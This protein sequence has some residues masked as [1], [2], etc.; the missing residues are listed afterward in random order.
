MDYSGE[1]AGTGA[2]D[3]AG[4]S[5]AKTFTFDLNGQKYFFQ[6]SRYCRD[7]IDKLL[8]EERLRELRLLDAMYG[9]ELKELSGDGGINVYQHLRDIVAEFVIIDEY[10]FQDEAAFQ[11]FLNDLRD[12][13]KANPL[14]FQSFLKTHEKA[15]KKAGSLYPM[16][17]I[18]LN[19]LYT[20]LNRLLFLGDL[21][22]TDPALFSWENFRSRFEYLANP[23]GLRLFV[24]Q[25]RKCLEDALRNPA[26]RKEAEHILEMDRELIAVD[27]RYYWNVS[28][29]KIAVAD[30]MKSPGL[31]DCF[32]AVHKDALLKLLK[33]PRAASVAAELLTAAGCEIPKVPE[34]S[35]PEENDPPCEE[36]PLPE[37]KPIS[38]DKLPDVPKTP[39]LVPGNIVV[40]GR[41]PEDE[42]ELPAPVEWQVLKVDEDAAMTG[43][44]EGSPAPA[45]LL[46]SRF[47]LECRPFHGESQSVSWENSD[48]RSW[49]NGEFLEKTFSKEEQTLL[50][51]SP[52]TVSCLSAEEAEE[53]FKT[54]AARISQA[55]PYAAKNGAATSSPKTRNCFIWLRSPGLDPATAA[56]IDTAG[57]ICLL[58]ED[59]SSGEFAVRP[60]I[61]ISL[62][63]SNLKSLV[64]RNPADSEKQND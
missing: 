14:Y 61:R 39:V 46:I 54:S 5:A 55:T 60:L 38:E 17:G 10:V 64:I 26:A 6:S 45:A 32:A 23:A 47:A 1:C 28:E 8:S 43:G 63:G 15:L 41:Y 58:G 27:D 49:L 21:V 35:L 9:E 48:L 36:K 37:D 12:S 20:Q 3:S 4:V 52:D 7:F 31:R 50:L 53:L 40:L 34:V 11:R 59:V 19:K 56:Y 18:L 62:G 57:D 22:I 16:T 30:I 24:S 2:A 25:H 42:D 13:V 29:F 51:K 44:K 33:N